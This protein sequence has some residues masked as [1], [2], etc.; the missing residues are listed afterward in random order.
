MNRIMPEAELRAW[1]AGF[2]DGEGCFSLNRTRA[3]ATISQVDRE[4]IDHFHR[5]VGC[6]NVYF[7]AG[8]FKNPRQR[9]FYS[10]RIGAR[11][12][13]DH[14]V[15]V[16]WPWLG[17]VKRA[18]AQR[19]AEAA[20]PGGNI[21]SRKTSCPAGHEYSEQNTRWVKAGAGRGRQCRQCHLD[22][23]IARQLERGTYWCA[24]LG[25]EQPK[26]RGRGLR[27]CLECKSDPTRKVA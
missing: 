10:W 27:Y 1:A 13:F 4:T 17:T 20:G 8:P 3:V 12:D 18:A 11:E 16:L 6:G 9:S 25:C 19:V 21:N 5:I 22:R 26:E 23:T 24:T 14:V 7:T 15:A 2:F